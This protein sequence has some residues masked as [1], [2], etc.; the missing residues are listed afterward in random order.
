M[1]IKR[2]L[3]LALVKASTGRNIAEVD[4]YGFIGKE[5]GCLERNPLERIISTAN[6]HNPDILVAPELMFYDGKRILSEDEKKS[7]EARIAQEV[8]RK[9]MLVMPGT[10]MWHNPKEGGLVKNTLPVITKGRIIAERMKA[11]D[12]GCEGIAKE[13]GLRYARGPEEGTVFPWKGL[14]IGLEIC[15]DHSFGSL[16]STGKKVDIHVVPAC[17]MMHYR[18]NNCS[19]QSGYFIICNGFK[20]G[21]NVVLQRKGAEAFEPVSPVQKEILGE[22][23]L[24]EIYSLAA[25]VEE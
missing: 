3:K 10:I 20:N 6:S 1:R 24:V 22:G 15:S 25:E 17:G 9:D 5:Y 4:E 8:S 13:H 7:I 16:V 21:A 12:G 18:E 23:S 19:R 14:D 2:N 11:T